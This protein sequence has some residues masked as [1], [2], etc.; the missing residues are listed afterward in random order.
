MSK[1]HTI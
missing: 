1:H